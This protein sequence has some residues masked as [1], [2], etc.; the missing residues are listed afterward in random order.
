MLSHK[1]LSKFKIEN[2]KK[3]FT[4]ENKEEKFSLDINEQKR[5]I[6]ADIDG[7][8]IVSEVIKKFINQE[9]TR[10]NLGDDTGKKR[11]GTI[12][13]NY[14]FIVKLLNFDNIFKY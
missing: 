14:H 10:L 9:I 11:E 6:S 3:G 1:G 7:L 5:L 12:H 8:K 13:L 2:V 4:N